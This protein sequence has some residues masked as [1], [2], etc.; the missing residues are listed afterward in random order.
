MPI[1]SAGSSTSLRGFTLIEVLVVL[2]IMALVMVVVVPAISKTRGGSL[3]D[4]ARDLQVE[5]RRTR[6]AAVLQ[7]QS[8]SLVL[9]VQGRSY[10]QDT[11]GDDKRS[12][13]RDIA[14]RA[15]VASTELHDGLAAIRFFPDGSSTGGHVRLAG[16]AGGLRIDVDWLSGKVS[17]HEESAR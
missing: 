12:I 9:D 5:L 14:V 2:V 1:S 7:Q 17:L 8:R 4:V 13:G 15:R 6:S 16:A 3:S 11:A 10:W